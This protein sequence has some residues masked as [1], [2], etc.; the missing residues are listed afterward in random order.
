MVKET[1]LMIAGA[2]L[3]IGGAPG[4]GLGENFCT[5]TSKA[6][7][8]ACAN[9]AKDDF[10]IA[11]GICHN[12]SD[13]D[14]REEC[15]D[16][17]EEARDE[18]KEECAE[19]YD[20]R[21]ELC[22]ALGQAPYDPVI[23]PANFLSPADTA[24]SPNPYFPLVPGTTWVY[25]GGGE[26]V[27]VTV[28]NET[29]EIL[30]VMAMVVNDVVEDEEGDVVEDTDDWYAQDVDGNVWYVGEIAKNFE[31]GELVDIEG[32]WTAGVEGARAGI[33]M[34]ATPAVSNVYRQEF[35][36]GDA[37]DAAEVISTTGSE[38]VP[39][40]SCDGDCVV[41]RDFTP[42]EPDHEENKYYAPGVGLILEV[43]PETGERLEL[44]SVMP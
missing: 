39:A 36:L 29:K 14:A 22:D 17:A 2:M 34:K 20:A 38:S 19:Q 42:L 8:R 12:V 11:V 13:D 7:R 43:D 1:A 15:A 24:A 32:S 5:K 21:E 33:V 44:V 28:T 26:T 10:W 35:A 16:E 27:T 9:E 41:T 40:A 23:D 4:T 6:A 31:D 30:G 18:A 3:F 37:E 25:E